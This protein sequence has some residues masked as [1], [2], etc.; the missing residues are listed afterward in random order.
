[1]P[2]TNTDRSWPM[3]ITPSH[4]RKELLDSLVEPRKGLA[5]PGSHI[6]LFARVDSNPNSP[7]GFVC[8]FLME[9]YEGWKE[10]DPVWVRTNKKWWPALTCTTPHG[11]MSSLP[12]NQA[13]LAKMQN[14]F[15][16]SMT[17]M[18]N[19]PKLNEMKNLCSEQRTSI[20]SLGDLGTKYLREA[21]KANKR[22]ASKLS[23]QHS[24]TQL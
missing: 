6:H 10:D 5:S 18:K 7:L 11:N 2:V 4:E 12:K 21:A 13:F 16:R 14:V 3:H 22:G 1:V 17:D 8:I 20:E 9:K 24:L 15:K 23:L 19:W